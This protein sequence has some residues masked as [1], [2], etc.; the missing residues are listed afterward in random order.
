M[1]RKKEKLLERAYR[2]LPILGAIVVLLAIVIFINRSVRV[3]FKNSIGNRWLGAKLTA[4]P[5]AVAGRLIAADRA[6]HDLGRGIGAVHAP[7]P[8]ER[9]VVRDHEVDQRGRSPVAIDASA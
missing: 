6:V 2:L 7:A 5:A 8:V 1:T 9:R 3:V 4:Q